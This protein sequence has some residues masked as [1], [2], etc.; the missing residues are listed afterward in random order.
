MVAT[1]G[2]LVIRR[3][4]EPIARVLPMTH[5]R[6]PPDHADLRRRM[7]LLKTSSADLI[8]AERDEC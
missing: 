5:Q 7:P 2:E 3:R 6:R 4:G 8:R 1:E